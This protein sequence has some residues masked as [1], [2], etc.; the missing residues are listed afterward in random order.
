M[1]ASLI[2]N[3]ES[4][5]PFDEAENADTAAALEF[6]K[7]FMNNSFSRENIV[8][9]WTAS[10]FV[11]NMEQT[12]VLFAHHNIY[13]KFC[14]LGGHCDGNPDLLAV[15]RQEVMEES[16]LTDI[17]RIDNTAPLDDIWMGAI[18]A[19]IK[20]GKY[21]NA[22]LHPNATFIFAAD[23]H[24]PIKIKPDENSKLMW[25]PLDDIEKSPDIEDHLRPVYLRLMQKIR[26]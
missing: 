14:W 6:T 4:H 10:A 18:Y 13:K 2:A 20:R 25:F 11:I 7:T 8:G 12:K 16:G 5:T 23:E 9:H 26:G 19:H 3:L 22:H 21:V 24:S 15:A 1:P 17:Q